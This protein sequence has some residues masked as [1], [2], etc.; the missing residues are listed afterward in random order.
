MNDAALLAQVPDFIAIG[1]ML[2]ASPVSNGGRR[3][4]Y[5]EA[6]NE[7]VDQQGESV[8]AKALADSADFYRRYGNVDIEHLTLLGP[9]LG[10]ANYQGYEIGR[11]VDVGQADKKTF[12]KAEI[13]SGEGPAAVQA[14]QFWS[15][16]ADI[17]PPARW[18][19]S[20]AGAVKNRD[21]AVDP[22]TGMRKAIITKVTWSNIGV[23]KTPVNQH[24]PTCQ[25][26]PLGVFAKCLTADGGIDIA[27]ALEAGYGTDSASLT[28]GG[29]LREQSL[30]G[31]R[32]S[33]FDLRNKLSAAMLKG[34]I[35]PDPKTADLVAYTAKKFGVSPGEAA[36]HVERF[37]SDIH[38]GLKQRRVK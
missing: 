37:V 16:I 33:Y 36:E 13:Y 2:K 27:K 29:A 9:K 35:G 23:S 21:I 1:A 17:T 26:V 19:P 12:V 6:S 11:P 7:G 30:Y 22:V 15:S 24:V 14:N 20:V 28:G 10:I 4:V 34:E 32:V 25:T 18:Y 5:F 3:F 38:T 31:G 8:A